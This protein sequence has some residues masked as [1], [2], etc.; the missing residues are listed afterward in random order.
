[1]TRIALLVTALALALPATAGAATIRGAVVGGSDAAGA[2]WPFIAALVVHGQPAMETQFCG[3]T[4]ADAL[5]VITAAHCTE[6]E[7]AADIDVVVGRTGLNDPVGQRVQVASVAVQP[8][9]DND[10][11]SHDVAI[12]R[13]REPLTAPAT[14]RPASADEAALGRAGQDVRVAGWGY[15][16]ETP[17]TSPN[18]LQDAPLTIMGPSRCRRGYDNFDTSLMIC[19]GT[20]GGGPPGTCQG[21]SGGP[22]VGGAAEDP[23]LV[24]IVSFGA[25]RCADPEIPAGYTRVSAESEFIGKQLGGAAPPPPGPS[26]PIEDLDPHVQI[27]RIWCKTK[28]YVEVGASGDGAKRVPAV[29]VRVRR[30]RRGS[31]K[32]TDRTYT[33]KRLTNTRWRARVGLPFG[34]LRITARAVDFSNRTIGNPDRVAVEVVPE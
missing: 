25:A 8:K 3:G 16:S 11:L 31:R 20:R 14:L 12:L 9:Y 26:P 2:D 34:V 10:V 19:A 17:L 7:N 33:A 15:V 18:V 1:M 5:H 28:C 24:G 13:L 22:L 23:R 4:V 27:G 30:A 29:L 6:G 32:G 21:D